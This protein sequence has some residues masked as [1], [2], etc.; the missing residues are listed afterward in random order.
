LSVTS[1]VANPSLYGILL[2]ILFG[3]I[4]LVPLKVWK[5][6]GRWL[7]LGIAGVILFAPSIAWVQVPIQSA[8]TQAFMSYFGRETINRQILWLGLPIIITS[9][10]VQELAKLLPVIIYRVLHRN[11]LS[12]VQGIS[13]GAITGAGYGV[14]ESQWALNSIFASGW[15]LGFYQIY[16]ISA[17]LGF[18]ERFFTTGF[19]IATASLLGYGLAQGKAWQ[20][21][22]IAVALHS[23]INYCAVLLQRG[24]MSALQVEILIAFMT[25]VLIVVITRIYFKHQ[26]EAT[27]GSGIQ[28]LVPPSSAPSP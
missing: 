27:V 5:W 6:R 24:I 10:L 13:A 25:T 15:T 21:Y 2:S 4:W 23:M 20:F 7:W 9:G 1:F 28:S 18:W 26:K 17:F 16:G 19:H 3:I 8:I 14:F 12:P 11:P 22:L